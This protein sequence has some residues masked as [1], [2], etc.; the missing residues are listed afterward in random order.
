MSGNEVS[1]IAL[2]VV[3]ERVWEALMLSSDIPRFQSHCIRTHIQ[4][5]IWTHRPCSLEGTSLG[6]SSMP[7]TEAPVETCQEL[8]VYAQGVRYRLAHCITRLEVVLRL[9]ALRRPALAKETL[10]ESPS[11]SAGVARAGFCG[12]SGKCSTASRDH[13]HVKDIAKH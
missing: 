7:V 4:S 6:E 12:D 5:P 8:T 9:S 11:S 10:L 1:T 3:D 2:T 13:L